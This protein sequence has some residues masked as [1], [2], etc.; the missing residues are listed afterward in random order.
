MLN[1][2][3]KAAGAFL[4]S[5]M[6][7]LTAC[8]AGAK[9]EEKGPLTVYRVE[10]DALYMSA[11][12]T[13]QK[14]NPDLE[15]KTF[16]TYQE[17][18][19]QLNTELMSGK[20]PDVLLYNSLYSESDPLKLADSG[21]FLSLDE[22]VKGLSDDEYFG[23]I[24]EA[25]K[26]EGTQY[27]LP[28]S[29]NVPL[30]Y[31]SQS[32]AKEQNYLD[33]IVFDILPAEAKR[34]E[35]DSEASPC[36]IQFGRTDGINFVAEMAGTPVIN[37]NGEITIDQESFRHVAELTKL[38]VE[39]N[40]KINAQ[41]YGNDFASVGSHYSFFLENYSFMHNLRFYQV[42][43]HTAFNEDVMMYPIQQPDG[44][45]TAQ[46]INYGAVNANSRNP[47]GAWN[48]L[49]AI[50]DAP[51]TMDYGKY[52]KNN[53]YYTPVNVSA[54]EECVKELFLQR[55][56]IKNTREALNEENSEILRAFPEKVTSAL[57]PNPSVGAL[58]QDCMDPYLTGDKDFESCYQ[59]L[60]SKLALYLDE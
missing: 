57:I 18:K 6:L 27:L 7:A 42:V 40:S 39:S 25:G 56:K 9:P 53:I 37:H 1:G 50:A 10:S 8:N 32:L 3:T 38:L 47:D 55:A 52:E 49:K 29:W 51:C 46:V 26:I 41:K 30:A 35:S 17:M 23:T 2:R 28:L 48:L 24:L 31:T 12:D 59:E 22:Y 33:Q 20:G 44:G 16:P 13:Y 5:G 21:A 43:F 14:E 15:I 36:S 34:L 11:L 45:V 54:Y 60:M 4:L 58:V 19:D